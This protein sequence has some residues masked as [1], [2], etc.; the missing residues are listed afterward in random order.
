[1]AVRRLAMNTRTAGW[2]LLI[3][4]LLLASAV[5]LV[6]AEGQKGGKASA[7]NQGGD[8]MEKA[9]FAG[10]CFWCIQGAFEDVKGVKSVVSGY[11]GGRGRNPTYEDYAEKGY[12]EAVEVTYD[13]G[14]VTYQRL[15]DVYW[16]QID[17]T[18]PGG[19]FVDRGPQ[20]RTV[21]FYRGDAQKRLAE[22]SKRDLAA[23]HRFSKPIVTE[24]TL[25]TTF[26]AAEEYHQDFHSKSPVRYETYRC[27]SGRDEFLE[28][29][30]GKDSAAVAKA[31]PAEAARQVTDEKPAATAAAEKPAPTDLKKT[32]TPMQYH[33]TQ[34][35]GTEPP[36]QNEFW[37]NHREGIYVDVVTGQALFSSLDKFDS[38]CGWPSFSRTIEAGDVVEK[39]D[40]SFG[41][42]R[43]EVRSSEGGSHLGHV[44][45]DGPG[46][47]GLR[48]CINSASLRFIPKENLA[49]EGYGKFLVL[50]EK[51]P[52]LIAK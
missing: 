25:S 50:F 12:V 43:T 20:Y 8:A 22:K 27:F 44:F 1:M 32:L 42:A 5:G 10:G 31:V 49:K 39:T 6:L 21:I 38:E 23:S 37:N 33:V 41:M 17:P 16:R 19:Q 46:P 3:G 2:A 18:D 52:A 30:W 28:K 40:R 13:P 48:Y 51:K 15:L 14:K 26:T 29:V 9:T 7:T 24:I 36:F 11:A 47:T 4:G 34:E 45:N 35:N